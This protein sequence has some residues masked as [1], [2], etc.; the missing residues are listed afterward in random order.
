MNNQHTDHRQAEEDRRVG[1]KVSG[2]GH[3]QWQ[4]I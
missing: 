2:V 4:Q 3:Q 1:R